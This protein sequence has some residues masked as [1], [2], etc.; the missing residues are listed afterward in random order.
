MLE[1]TLFLLLKSPFLP[2]K[3]PSKELKIVLKEASV[4]NNALYEGT[5]E[6]SKAG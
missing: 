1:D 3:E 4:S 2:Q 5:N 6:H